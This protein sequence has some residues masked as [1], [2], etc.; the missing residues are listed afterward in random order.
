MYGDVKNH[1]LN[2]TLFMRNISDVSYICID[3]LENVYV[4]SMFKFELFG[5]DWI[6]VLLG[7]IQNLLGSVLTINKIY[8]KVIEYPEEQMLRVYYDIGRIT[9]MI[10]DFEPIILEE[11]VNPLS[12]AAAN[13]KDKGQG[14]RKTWNTGED[15]DD[16]DIIYK[17][18]S[19]KESD[20]TS[21]LTAVASVGFALK[22]Q[23]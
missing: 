17:K 23:Q 14:G 5:M 15:D 20:Y 12:V 19:W 6:N 16:D 1:I 10:L 4:F 11:S 2:T 22:I 7:F 8:Q 3:A 21:A 9:K 13:S 18:K